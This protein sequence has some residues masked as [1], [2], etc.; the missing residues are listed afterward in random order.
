MQKLLN[1]EDLKKIV[2][3]LTARADSDGNIPIRKL[4]IRVRG[5][6]E[7]EYEEQSVR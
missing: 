7:A 5:Y 2:R 6:N 3:I 1:D 4:D